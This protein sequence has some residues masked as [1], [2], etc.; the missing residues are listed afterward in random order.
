[1][2]DAVIRG[3]WLGR[4]LILEVEAAFAPATTLEEI[5][6]VG[7]RVIAAVR[8]ADEEVRRVRVIPQR[9]ATA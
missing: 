9:K 3:R 6:A 7:Q 4:T 5:E 8:T 2:A 1:M